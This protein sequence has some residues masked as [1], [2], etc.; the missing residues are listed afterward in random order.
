MSELETV[1]G[2]I[3]AGLNVDWS[4][5]FWSE[6]PLIN[7]VKPYCAQQMPPVK[8][9]IAAVK[10]F[11]GCKRNVAMQFISPEANPSLTGTST[12]RLA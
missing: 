11:Q 6:F 4:I 1:Y 2:V 8:R 5:G 10:Q 9:R 3:G 12:P 7:R